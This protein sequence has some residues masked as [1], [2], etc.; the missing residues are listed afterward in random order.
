MKKYLITLLFLFVATTCYAQSGGA[1]DDKNLFIDDGTTIT[2]ADSR[3][4]EFNGSL[5]VNKDLTVYGVIFNPG[6]YGNL[7]FAAESQEFSDDITLA[8]G[9]STS[10]GISN[11]H[12]SNQV[13][14]Q[15]QETDKFDMHF[16]FEGQSGDPAKVSIHGRYVGNPSHDVW[17]YGYNY[18]S[19]GWVRLTAEAQDFPSRLTVDDT[20]SFNFPL[21]NSDYIANGQV[22]VRIFHNSSAVSSHYMYIDEICLTPETLA[23]TNAGTY[24]Q[25]TG[26]TVGQNNNTTLDGSAGTITIDISGRYDFA[27][28]ISFSGTDDATIRGKV[29]KNDAPA[30]AVTFKRKLGSNGDVGS[31]SGVGILNLVAGDVLKFYFTSDKDNS[32]MSVDTISIKLNRVG[33]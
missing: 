26:F 32:F 28:A 1:W 7:L 13:Y 21:T 12:S 16:G 24:Y 8:A 9:T 14:W 5:S 15:V 30:G 31:A 17:I 19:A 11:I 18:T 29:Y 23:F 2:L 22:Q 10:G 4:V 20:Y 33:N 25:L 6:V 27:G 3:D